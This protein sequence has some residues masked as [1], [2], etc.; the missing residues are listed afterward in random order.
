[1]VCATSK[2]SEQP[3]QSLCKSLEYSMNFQLLAE[4]HLECLS[5]KGGYTVW[6]E[7]TL[8]KVPLC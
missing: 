8:V 1:M 2:G 7:S 4:Q 6:P 3:D 5:L